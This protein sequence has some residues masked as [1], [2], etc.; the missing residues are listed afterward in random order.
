M[1][2]S[3]REVEF[4]LQHFCRVGKDALNRLLWNHMQRREKRERKERLLLSQIDLLK[5]LISFMVEYNC[6]K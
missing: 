3:L 4:H 2:I 6:H 5:Y 1:V